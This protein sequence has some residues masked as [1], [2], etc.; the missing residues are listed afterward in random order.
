VFEGADGASW[1]P[2]EF[3]AMA[4]DHGS[5]LYAILGNQIKSTRP[6]NALTNKGGNTRPKSSSQ[7]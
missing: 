1:A 6:V 3:W 4:G 5:G 7:A 2:G